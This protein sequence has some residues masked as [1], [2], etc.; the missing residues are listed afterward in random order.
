[1]K[2]WKKY[3]NYLHSGDWHVHTNYTDGK[4]TVFEY[5]EK[6]QENGLELIAF[7]EH[8][9]RNLDYNFDDF[10][11]DVYSAKDHFDLN[12]L[13]GC[14]AKVLD[15]RGA[16]DV[17]KSVLD[18]CE[19]VLGA[20]HKFKINK[21]RYLTAIENMLKNLDV[22]IWAHPTL[23]AKN[24]GFELSQD[25]LLRIVNLCKEEGV[26]IE[27]NIR[28]DLPDER[29]MKLILKGNVDFVISSDAHDISMLLNTE[30]LN[31]YKQKQK[32][33]I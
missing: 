32:Y 1:M 24:N 12:V 16:L 17:S 28:Y 6:A 29:F 11:S 2:R 20:F 23:F 8:V 14:E 30:T 19:V 4:N 15:L 18:E 22:D 31:L 7:T 27:R 3:E 5:C 33:L 13:V 9:R 25:D 26:L 21:K 10:I